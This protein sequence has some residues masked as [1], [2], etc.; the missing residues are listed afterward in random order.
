MTTCKINEKFPEIECNRPPLEGD[1][2]HLCLLHSRLEDKDKDGA[3]TEVV[4]AKLA[5]EDYD[6]RGVFFPG[7]ADF[8]GLEFKK[9]ADFSSATFL[10]DTHFSNVTF[11]RAA[12]FSEVTFSGAAFFFGATF[13]GAAD[14]F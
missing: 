10:G 6:F 12:D 3:F 8:S 2:K 5:Q 7:E 13:S 4:K 14:F 1:P 9:D 11:S